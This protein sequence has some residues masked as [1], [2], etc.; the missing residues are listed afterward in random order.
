[1]TQPKHNKALDPNPGSVTALRCCSCGVVSQL[2]RYVPKKIYWFGILIFAA[3]AWFAIR[4]VNA[5]RQRASVQALIEIDAQVVYQ[6]QVNR[7]SAF[8]IPASEPPGPKWLHPILGV[9]FFDSVVRVY[10]DFEFTDEHVSLL[11]GLPKLRSF[12]AEGSLLTDDGISQITNIKTIQHLNVSGSRLTDK[13]SVYFQKMPNLKVLQLWQTSIT[14]ESIENLA[15]LKNLK[16]LYLGGSLI[17]KTAIAKLK[18]EIPDCEIQWSK[19]EPPKPSSDPLDEKYTDLL[20]QLM[21]V[22]LNNESLKSTIKSYGPDTIDHVVLNSTGAIPWPEK[23]ESKSEGIKY[24]HLRTDRNARIYSKKL[25]KSGRES[26]C[27]R[28]DKFN[29]KAK[30]EKT[31]IFDG[32]II[33]VISN[34]GGNNIGGCIASFSAQFIDHKWKVDFKSAFDP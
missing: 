17:T 26:L 1:M 28:I 29:L 19:R 25:H 5:E 23:F 30:K 8:F 31:N 13:G 22:V 3:L 4:Y 12:Q 27:L 24:I 34:L 32:P 15:K 6:N 20:H 9:D 21:T 33:V 7:M 18:L 16:S 2:K 11:N 10:G 14:D